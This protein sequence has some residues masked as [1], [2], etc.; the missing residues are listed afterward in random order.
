VARGRLVHR[1]LELLPDLAPAERPAVASALAGRS[2]VADSERLVADT[3]AL[4]KDPA[5]A[6]LFGPGSRAEVP[7]AGTLRAADGAILPV[8]GRIDRVWIGADAVVI[9]DFKTDTAVPASVGDL[10]GSYR[11]QLALYRAL[12]AAL[13]PGKRI[14][15]WL[16]FT[17]RPQVM[18]VPDALLDE[19]FARLTSSP[20][21]P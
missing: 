6:P 12:L 8:S 3:L 11:R 21:L 10:A 16:V 5:L 18:P 19:T 7:L 14:A 15:C 17:C 1:L 4:I 2:G 9:A 20:T 13:F